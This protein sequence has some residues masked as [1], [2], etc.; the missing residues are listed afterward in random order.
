MFNI[1]GVAR[2]LVEAIRWRD[3]PIVQNLVMFIAVVVV[4]VN[5]LVDMAYMVARSAHQ[6]R[7]LRTMAIID[8]DGELHA[9]GANVTGAGSRCSS[10]R[11]AI[12]WA[13]SAPIIVLIFVLTAVFA[14]FIAPF[15]PTSTNRA[16]L[17]RRP[18]GAHLARRRLHGPR[19]VEPHR[20]RRAHL[21]RRRH[22]RHPLGCLIGVSIGLRRGYLRRLARPARA[23][24][25][26]HH[27]VAAAAGD[28]AGDGRGARAV[29]QNTI[30][31]IA[32]PLVP[33]V[34]RVIRSNTLIA[35][36]DAVRRG[37]PRRSA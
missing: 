10:R 28:G 29:A 21:A 12:R 6:V 14:D 30:I 22:G 1:P 8:H 33:T 32:I 26:G 25:H 4:T 36:R 34:A 16:R 27:A 17:A 3:Y 9:A 35:A 15:D 18:G 20:L 2:F 7:G 5:F 31:A 24:P 19:H 11:G 37:G 13:R 23:A